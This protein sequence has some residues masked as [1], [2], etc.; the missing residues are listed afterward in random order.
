VEVIPAI[1]IRGGQCVRL[2][3]G[4]YDRETV[5]SDSP[6]D[7]AAHWVERG[8]TRL[9]IVDLDGAR[10]GVAPNIETVAEIAASSPVP[11]QY[12][13][14][15]R[16]VDSAL[17]AVEMGVDRVVVGTAAVEDPGLVPLLLGK[18]DAGALVVSVDARDGR[19]ALDG[20]TRGSGVDAVDFARGLESTGV[21]RVVYTDISRDGT[22]TEPNFTGVEE[23]AAATGM[24]VLVAGG[25]SSV[26]QVTRLAAVPVEG[27]IVGSAVYTGAIDLGEAIAAVSGAQSC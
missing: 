22:L 3:Q 14:G 8:A 27:A 26:E 12:G 15:V 2:F 13:G 20:W 10:D 7:M 19:I 23:L 24:N 4:D 21:E 11:V 18:L 6:V 25:V 9:H 17:R 5:F 1:D 16:D